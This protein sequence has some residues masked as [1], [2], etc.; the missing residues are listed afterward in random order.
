MPARLRP[1]APNA[2]DVILVGDPGRALLLAQGLL[3]E[4]KMSNHARGLWGY[5]GR[6]AAGHELTIQSTGMGGPS[7]AV[8]LGDLAELGVRRAVRIGSCTALDE[9]WA[10]GEL[11]IVGAAHAVGP[12]TSRPDPKLTGA[13]AHQLGEGAREAAVASLDVIY[14]PGSVPPGEGEVADMQTAAVFS[15]GGELGVAVAAVLIV[16][17]AEAGALPDAEL[18]EAAR[19][20]GEAAAAV[21]ST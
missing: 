7:A 1:T 13:L 4:P 3:G 17:E 10:P 15:R 9:G 12:G 6:T 20:A 11:A 14:R 5:S 19:R 18:E 8:V 21:L 16:A 2:A